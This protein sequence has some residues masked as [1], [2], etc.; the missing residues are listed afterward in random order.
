MSAGDYGRA[1][2]A[3]ERLDRNL[4]E[5]LGGLRVALPGVQVLFAFLLVL[6]FQS[7]FPDV[8][9][10]QERVYFGTLLCTAAAS[11]LLIAPSARHRIRFRKDDKAYVV[12]TA[13]RLAIAGLAFLGLGMA[14]AVLLISDFLFSELVAIVATG[15]VVVGVGWLWFVSPLARDVGSSASE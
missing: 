14:G 5:L 3:K 12:F 13:N 9:P 4:E 8:T 11:I 15:A 10:F 2:S 1:E 6:P 7:R